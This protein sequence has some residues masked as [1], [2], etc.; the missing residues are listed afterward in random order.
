M[1]IDINKQV[2]DVEIDLLEEPAPEDQLEAEI[3]VALYH[4][5][6]QSADTQGF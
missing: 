4:I 2:T 6:K 5:G 3:L 1:R